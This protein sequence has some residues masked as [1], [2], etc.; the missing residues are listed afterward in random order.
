MCVS[1]LNLLE[2]DIQILLFSFRAFICIC[3]LMAHLTLAL[4]NSSELSA[5]PPTA[6]IVDE[7]EQKVKA[8]KSNTEKL[9]QVFSLLVNFQKFL[10]DCTVGCLHFSIS[11]NLEDMCSL[12]EKCQFLLS[13]LLGSFR[14]Q[15]RH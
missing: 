14:V 9:Q 3:A 13:V 12:W 4:A 11:L 5:S 2:E 7:Q 1:A 8:E 15:R 10:S 6:L